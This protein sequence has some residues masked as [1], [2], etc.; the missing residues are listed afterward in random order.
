MECPF[1]YSVPTDFPLTLPACSGVNIL[2][3]SC[4]AD[5]RST[6]LHQTMKTAVGQLGDSQQPQQNHTCATTMPSIIQSH[7]RIKTD[8]AW[9]M[10]QAPSVNNTR[11]RCF[12]GNP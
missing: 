12:L 4:A 10:H 7:V 3:T 5:K 6:A 11:K 9:R 2:A 1:L 8:P